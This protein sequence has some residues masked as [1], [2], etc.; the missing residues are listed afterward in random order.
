MPCLRRNSIPLH[1]GDRA[2]VV[3]PRPRARFARAWRVGY[4]LSD[5]LVF[6]I[7][8]IASVD[9]DFTLYRARDQRRFNH[10]FFEA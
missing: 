1:L 4:T 3:Q 8:D 6:K 9:S 7:W 10:R 5:I 2:S